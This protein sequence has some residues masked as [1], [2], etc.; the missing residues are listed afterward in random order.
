[1]EEGDHTS[2]IKREG[3]YYTLLGQ[4]YIG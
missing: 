1:V 3:Y 2:L 4:Q